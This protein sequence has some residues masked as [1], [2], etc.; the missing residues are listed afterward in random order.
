MFNHRYARRPISAEPMNRV[1]FARTVREQAE[2]SLDEH[3]TRKKKRH[4]KQLLDGKIK[5]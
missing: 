4:H 3:S 1:K 5:F 2:R